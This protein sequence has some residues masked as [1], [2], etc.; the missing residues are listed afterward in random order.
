MTKPHICL[1]FDSTLARTCDVAFELLCG[2]DHDYTYDD[3]ESL[4]WGLREF[5]NERYLNALWHAWT[6][7]GDDI[8]PFPAE[9]EAV[10]TELSW[11]SAQLDVVTEHP[12]HILGIDEAKRA[13]LDANNIV[14]D[15]YRSLDCSKSELDYDIY[16]DDKPS[17]VSELAFDDTSTVLL[18]D[19]TYNRDVQGP[20]TRINSLNDAVS[21]IY[22]M[23]GIDDS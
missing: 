21:Y 9:P 12:D 7:R 16:I 6:L 19:H 18:Y 23:G 17:L 2:P 15:E 22:S 1:D 13:W 20:C 3:I 8:E 4:E 14:Y 5:G 10:T 11:C